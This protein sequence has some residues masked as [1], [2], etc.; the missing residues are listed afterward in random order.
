MSL[1]TEQISKIKKFINSRG[2]TAIEVELESLDHMASKIEDL[3]AENP[4]LSFDLAISKAH[5]SFGIFGL[6]SIEE[7]IRI[8]INKRFRKR[9]HKEIFSLF[10]TSR[11]LLLVLFLVLGYIF[12]LVYLTLDAGVSVNLG[13]YLYAISISIIPYIKFRKTWK[14]WN[15]KSMIIQNAGIAMWSS[16]WVF[17]YGLGGVTKM[18]YVEASP[19]FTFFFVLTFTLC[20]L[21]ALFSY[22]IMKWGI[23]WAEERYLKYAS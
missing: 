5:S 1:S 9:L 11:I 22:N 13:F 8:G 6:S 14:A 12:Q 16:M 4:G 2:F 3:M 23:D 15:Q 19:W 21:S 20:S 18:L 10:T 7:S 17:G